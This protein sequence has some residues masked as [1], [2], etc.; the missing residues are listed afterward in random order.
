[1]DNTDASPDCKNQQSIGLRQSNNRS[2][3]SS[4]Q[5]ARAS[6]RL[7]R[8][9]PLPGQVIRGTYNVAPMKTRLPPTCEGL[10]DKVEKICRKG[11][12]L[13]GCT[14]PCP[15]KYGCFKHVDEDFL[16]MMSKKKQNRVTGLPSNCASELAV[17]TWKSSSSNC[18]LVTKVTSSSLFPFP[19][20]STLL[21]V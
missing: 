19:K 15:G 3:T 1:V 4:L 7:K 21:Q 14:T 6:S 20:S 9:D 10:C 18:G 16:G 11:R 12:S 8:N 13:G 5:L 17:G 2:K